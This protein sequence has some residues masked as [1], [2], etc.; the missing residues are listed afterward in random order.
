MTITLPPRVEQALNNAAREFEQ[1]GPEYLK[2]ILFAACQSPTG[3]V[4]NLTLPP[5]AVD[6]AQ[7]ALPLG[8]G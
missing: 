4:L 1:Q 8:G 2:S 3:V 6:P 5:M 7:L